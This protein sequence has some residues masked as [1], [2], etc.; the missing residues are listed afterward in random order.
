MTGLDRNGDGK[1]DMYPEETAAQ[2]SRLRVAGDDL[3]PAWLGNRA[4]IDAPGQI[5][6]GPMG[7]AFT[8][9]YSTP[10]TA[11]AG[12]MNQVPGVYRQLADNG[13]QAVRA[14]QA[15]DGAAA[16]QFSR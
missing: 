4:K 3:E 11:V 8:G 7:T 1:I 13:D 6:G 5:G 2:L 14:Y 16:S 10:K 9:L 15:V 12:A